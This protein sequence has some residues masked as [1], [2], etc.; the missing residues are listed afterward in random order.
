MLEKTK[1]LRLNKMTSEQ[2]VNLYN[3]LNELFES[4][5]TIRS[6]CEHFEISI[7]TYYRLKGFAGSFKS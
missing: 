1:R 5:Y 4:G 7:G 2:K 6:I 3:Q